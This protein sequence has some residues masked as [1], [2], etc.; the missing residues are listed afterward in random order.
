MPYS[1]LGDGLI[2]HMRNWERSTF[3]TVLY[4]FVAL[5]VLYAWS[6]ALPRRFSFQVRA[7]GTA[8]ANQIELCKAQSS[9]HGE[10]P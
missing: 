6:T 4:C 3:F 2:F 9:I 8:Q 7:F 1:G 5:S 10:I